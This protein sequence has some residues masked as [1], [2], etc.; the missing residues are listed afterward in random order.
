MAAVARCSQGSQA[1]AA[2]PRLGIFL[3]FIVFS[4][5]LLLCASRLQNCFC[6]APP[7]VSRVKSHHSKKPCASPRRVSM[8]SDSGTVR[9]RGT[10]TAK[11]R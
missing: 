11:G 2:C 3:L 7:A 6:A 9:W 8:A 5:L 1:G 10:S 4:F